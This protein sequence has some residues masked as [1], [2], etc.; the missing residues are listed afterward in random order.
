[1]TRRRPPATAD[2]CAC[3]HR[4]EAHDHY[5]PGS[6]CGACGST[7]CPRFRQADAVV[8]LADILD[9]PPGAPRADQEE[10]TA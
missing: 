1:M 10:P 4:R 2:P 6:D 7:R 3:G 8:A 5:R 9:P